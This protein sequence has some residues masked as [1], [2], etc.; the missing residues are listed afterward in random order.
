MFPNPRAGCNPVADNRSFL[1]GLRP[2]Q[3][4]YATVNPLV[5]SVE[6]R[7]VPAIR[8][9]NVDFRIQRVCVHFVWIGSTVASV[10]VRQTAQI[11]RG[12][13]NWSCAPLLARGFNSAVEHRFRDFTID[14]SRIDLRQARGPFLLSCLY[15]NR[16]A[17]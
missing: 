16:P 15:C 13:L 5:G 11:P 2:S 14:A 17:P 3:T 8:I 7:T 12:D 4:I 1:I 6:K 10:R 9:V